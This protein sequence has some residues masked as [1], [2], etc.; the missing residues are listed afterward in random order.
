M[1]KFIYHNPIEFERQ[2]AFITENLYEKYCGR[3]S[4]V[5]MASRQAVILRRG[6]DSKSVPGQ[7]QQVRIGNKK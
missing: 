1:I 6:Q 5:K 3:L 2:D 4:V 7:K